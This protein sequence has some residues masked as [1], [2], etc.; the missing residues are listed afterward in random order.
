MVC[1]SV[2]YFDASVKMYGVL[3]ATMK[4]INQSF[5]F[6]RLQIL[7][8]VWRYQR[9]LSGSVNLIQRKTDN[10]MGKRKSTKGQTMI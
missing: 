10:T 1:N 5:S 4:C 3:S 7:R 2:V 6:L 8:R 9:G